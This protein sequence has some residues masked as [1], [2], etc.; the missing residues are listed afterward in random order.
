MLPMAECSGNVVKP[1]FEAVLLPSAV[2]VAL[3]LVSVTPTA[4]TSAPSIVSAAPQSR[5]GDNSE[6]GACAAEG[7]KWL[8][9]E[10]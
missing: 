4:S 8:V 7:V 10:G 1:K 3:K 9:M 2:I 5:R 6:E